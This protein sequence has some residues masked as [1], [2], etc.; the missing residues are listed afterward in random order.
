MMLAAA[1]TAAAAAAV[2]PIKLIPKLIE[3]HVINRVTQL[4]WPPT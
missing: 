4:N 2:V 1:A 3:F